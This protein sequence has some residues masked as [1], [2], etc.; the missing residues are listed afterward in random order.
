MIQFQQISKN[1]GKT[2]ILKD[3]SMQINTGELICLVGPS[4]SGKTTLLKMV[5]RLVTPDKGQIL[6]DNQPIEQWQLRELRLQIGYVI[7]QIALFPHMT[8]Y[9]NI[10]L[11]PELK[12]IPK[13]KWPE[14]ANFWLNKV[15]LKPE[16][17]LSRYPKELSGGQQ[18]RVGIVRA[19]ITQPKILLMDE[20]FS[21]LDPLSRQQLQDL[22]KQLQ[23]ELNLTVLFVTHDMDEALKLADRI[24]V[25]QNGQL[26]QFASPT[27]I[28]NDPQ[29]AFIAQFLKG[30]EQ[31]A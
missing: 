31:N 2:A 27:V 7:Q 8:V 12:K 24:A 19:L 28:Q 3:L 30:R 25:L 14:M 29:T 6:L 15:G 5:N 26:V 4:G 16:E 23:E 21:A 10:T 13:N 20:P 17:V 11:I 1:Y 9:E 18:Q 22:L